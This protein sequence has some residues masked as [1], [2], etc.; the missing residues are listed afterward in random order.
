V[1]NVLCNLQLRGLAFDQDLAKVPGST[2]DTLSACAELF[3]VPAS[4]SPTRSA[5][6]SRVRGPAP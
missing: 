1:K 5:R 2:P 4:S 3:L 6:L